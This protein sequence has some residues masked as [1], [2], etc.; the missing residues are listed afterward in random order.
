MLL[1]VQ[2]NPEVDTHVS[3]RMSDLQ[4]VHLPHCLSV[5]QSYLVSCYTEMPA[6][7][8]GVSDCNNCGS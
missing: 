5:S 8:A 3:V 1:K 4:S 6:G 7:F 2:P